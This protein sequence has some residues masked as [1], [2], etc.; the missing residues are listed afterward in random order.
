MI[1]NLE[2]LLNKQPY[3]SADDEYQRL[4]KIRGRKPNWYSLFGGPGSLETLA[5]YLHRGA[6]YDIL[7]R[8]WSTVSHAGDL[9]NFLTQTD[10]GTPAFKPIRNN[11]EFKLFSVM[12][13]SFIL[14]ATMAMI[15]KFRAG[16]NTSLGRWYVKEVRSW[17]RALFE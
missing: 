5:K 1:N 9:S 7:Y 12:A 15:G 10:R 3:K 4:K 2:S 11:E 6:Q 8:Y 17:H 16:E 13:S 14:H